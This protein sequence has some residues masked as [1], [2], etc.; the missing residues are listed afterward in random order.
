M[1]G[2]DLIKAMIKCSRMII[3]KSEIAFRLLA[4]VSK[5]GLRA[6]KEKDETKW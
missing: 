2:L 4:S 5:H 6:K 1:V 3:L